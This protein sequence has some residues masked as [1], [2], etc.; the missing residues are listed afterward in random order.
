MDRLCV[1]GGPVP[2]TPSPSICPTCPWR[3][4]NTPTPEQVA[5]VQ[6][7]IWSGE[8]QPCLSSAERY[9][10]TTCLPWLAACGADTPD[11][12]ADVAAGRLKVGQL[13]RQPNWP[14]V[15]DRPGAVIAAVY[16]P[17]AK[18]RL[19]PL[20]AALREVRED[21]GLSQRDVARRLGVPV[22]QVRDHEA[23]RQQPDL[24]QVRAYADVCG[25]DVVVRKR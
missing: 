22:T 21:L 25:V 3:V 18:V 14:P 6:E 24:T 15:H 17:A 20:M 13:Q 23:G 11:I 19:D 5:A 9:A 4:R 16:R 8:P 1:H 10:D 7:A 12:V 2:I